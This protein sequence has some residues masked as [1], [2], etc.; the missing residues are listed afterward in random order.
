MKV[1]V[2]SDS[3]TPWIIVYEAPLSVG[4]YSQDTGVG[5][6]SLLQGIFPTRRS[7]LGLPHC[8]QILNH[9]SL[10]VCIFVFKKWG[11]TVQ[12]IW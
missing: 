3:A 10:I 8:R 6:H 7:N 5:C 12:I 2:V 1:K 9:L 4:F 11:H